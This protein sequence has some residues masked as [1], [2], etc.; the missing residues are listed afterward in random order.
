MIKEQKKLSINIVDEGFLP[1]ADYSGSVSG[2][3]SDKS[4]LF[5]YELGSAGTPV[6]D[7]ASL[8]MECLRKRDKKGEQ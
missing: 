4:E 2:T 5:S 8:T 3:N 1:E 7:K 6:I